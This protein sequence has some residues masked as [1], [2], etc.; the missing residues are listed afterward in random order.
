MRTV[1]RSFA[2]AVMIA[3]ALLGAPANAQ[4]TLGVA[5]MNTG[6]CIPFGCVRETVRFQ[7]VYNAS[8]FAGPAEFL[9][10]HA[11]SHAG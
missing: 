5:E 11:V 3:G 8:A 4:L 9:C 6:N 1:A 7:Q 10:V 2:S